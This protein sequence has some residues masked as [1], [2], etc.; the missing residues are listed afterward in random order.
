M[1]KFL[2][3]LFSLVLGI[4]LGAVGIPLAAWVAMAL[5][6]SEVALGWAVW[7]VERSPLPFYAPA[8]QVANDAI[9]RDSLV[10]AGLAAALLCLTAFSLLHFVRRALRAAN[11]SHDGKGMLELKTRPLR[12]GRPVEGNIWLTHGSARDS[13][14]RVELSCKRD[15]GSGRSEGSETPYSEEVEVAPVR[16]PVGWSLPFR[17]VVPPIAPP[18]GAS[19]VS[20]PG[21]SWRLA[22]RRSKSWLSSPSVFTLYLAPAAPEQLRPLEKREMPQKQPIEEI[23]RS[24]G[25]EPVLRELAQLREPSVADLKIDAPS[26]FADAT[27]GGARALD[28]FAYDRSTDIPQ[29]ASRGGAASP[30]SERVD[31]VIFGDLTSQAIVGGD[32]FRLTRLAPPGTVGAPAPPRQPPRLRD[33]TPDGARAHDTTAG[34]DRSA[35]V[36][37]RASRGGAGPRLRDATPGGAQAH[38]TAAYDR[39]TDVEEGASRGGRGAPTF[40]VGDL[41]PGG[42]RADDTDAYDRSTYAPESASSLP[43]KIVKWLF[44]AVFGG[45]LAVSAVALATA[46]LLSHIM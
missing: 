23:V 24:V 15:H 26:L 8:V 28:T 44:L 13:L 42:A 17:F 3:A 16:V 10:A 21:Y 7:L 40:S 39:S 35:D 38:D 31:P 33:A 20:G 45:V 4:A 27:P 32:P 36:E 11:E 29:G 6:R 12:V 2:A 30:E 41:T 25:K 34:Y 19:Y 22:F 5:Y 18:S 9:R 14:Y 37:E 1:G 46:V 43:G